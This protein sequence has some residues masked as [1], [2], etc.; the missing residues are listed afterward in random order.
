MKLL[1]VL[2]L[3]LAGCTTENNGV[4]HHVIV[5]FGVV[6]VN[7]TNQAAQVVRAKAFGIYCSDTPGTKLAVGY[8]NQT[9]ACIRTNSNVVLEVK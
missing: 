5:G 8:V 3:L 6:S 9:T 4:V 2:L 7:K 1:A